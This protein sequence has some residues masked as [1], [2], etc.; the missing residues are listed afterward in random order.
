[1]QLNAVAEAISILE[2]ETFRTTTK[3]D[4]AAAILFRHTSTKTFFTASGHQKKTE[5]TAKQTRE[6]YGAQELRQVEHQVKKLRLVELNY[7]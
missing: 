1:M 2:D 3:I 6:R 4:R 7:Y 5:P